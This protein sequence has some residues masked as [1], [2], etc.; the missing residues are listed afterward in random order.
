MTLH[1][2]II[3]FE[4]D[5]KIIFGEERKYILQADTL[6]R[7]TGL[8][9]SPLPPAHTLLWLL[10]KNIIPWSPKR[11]EDNDAAK[12]NARNQTYKKLV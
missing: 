12:L 5:I 7:L 6:P 11:K 9:P 8:A 4:I 3:K 2:R 10:I 1:R